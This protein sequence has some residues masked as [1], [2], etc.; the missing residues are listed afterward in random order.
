[1]QLFFICCTPRS[2]IK[3]HDPTVIQFVTL[4]SVL[5]EPIH[6]M[7]AVMGSADIVNITKTAE[8]QQH[9]Q[10]LLKRFDAIKAAK[11][12]NRRQIRVETT[13]MY[14]LYIKSSNCSVHK[15][16]LLERPISFSGR[17]LRTMAC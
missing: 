7:Y 4:L 3:I 6:E 14:E 13:K 15:A 8:Y 10:S 12:S 2:K 5:S 11:Y 9:K 1:M 17:A 16:L